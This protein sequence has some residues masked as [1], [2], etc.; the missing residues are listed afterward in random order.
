MPAEATLHGHGNLTCGYIL[1]CLFLGEHFLG[2]SLAQE[3]PSQG[4]LW[5]RWL[6]HGPLKGHLNPPMQARQTFCISDSDSHLWCVTKGPITS[7]TFPLL[8]P[9]SHHLRSVPW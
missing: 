5:G 7:S 9:R 3:S 4:C 1:A 8:G 2:I 6:G